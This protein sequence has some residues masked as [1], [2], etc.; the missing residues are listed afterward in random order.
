MQTDPHI[1][2]NMNKET[3]TTISETL[4]ALSIVASGTTFLYQSWWKDRQV[5][6]TA[7][8]AS[9]TPAM[10][11]V[12]ATNAG[13]QDL[14]IISATVK[15]KA[16]GNNSVKKLKI[17]SEGELI[18]RGESLLLTPLP[19]NLSTMVQANGKAE[20]P[21]TAK[22]DCTVHIEFIDPKGHAHKVDVPFQCYAACVIELP[23]SD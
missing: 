16:L 9:S 12:L 7:V 1:V 23:E 13:G 18:K 5:D 15:S 4:A 11:S 14:V 22:T 10:L 20:D 2:K 8:V 17:K 3:I 6:L 19:S 21:V